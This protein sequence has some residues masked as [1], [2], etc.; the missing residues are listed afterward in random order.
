MQKHEYAAAC[1]VMDEKRAMG[2]LLKAQ[3]A[4]SLCGLW[5]AANERVMSDAAVAIVVDIGHDNCKPGS[6]QKVCTTG[7]KETR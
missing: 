1:N 2:S 7:R 3:T 6:T 4:D 5:R